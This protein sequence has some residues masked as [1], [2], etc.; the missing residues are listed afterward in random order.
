VHP[1]FGA[2]SFQKEGTKMPDSPGLCP[3]RLAFLVAATLLK[4]GADEV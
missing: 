3:G 4:G 2:Y 1:P